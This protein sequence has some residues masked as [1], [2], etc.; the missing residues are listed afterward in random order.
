MFIDFNK[1]FDSLFH[2]KLWF[3]LGQ[4]GVPGKII[5]ILENLYRNSKAQIKLDKESEWFL[6]KRGV[7]QGIHSPQI[8]VTP[9]PRN[10]GL[11]TP[12]LYVTF[13]FYKP[14]VAFQ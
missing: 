13:F 9:P 14:S 4:Q 6:V 1:A 3:A 2:N 11:G 10:H 7:K 5:K 8:F 12:L